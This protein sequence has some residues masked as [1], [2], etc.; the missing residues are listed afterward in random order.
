MLKLKRVY[1]KPDRS[2][3]F[4]VLVDRLWP[5]GLTKESAAVGLWLKDVA[6]S[7]ELRK[8]FAHDPTRWKEFQARYRRE[9]RGRKDALALLTQK[10]KGQT[11]TL[12]YGARDQEHNGAIVLKQLLE[13]RCASTN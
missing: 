1:E 9:L 6:P 12:V 8:W 7:P 3:G 11:V 2:D 5:R 4:R 13:A 10:S